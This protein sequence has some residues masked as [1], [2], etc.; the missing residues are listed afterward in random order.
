V[1]RDAIVKRS[2]G[3]AIVNAS[4]VAPCR[5]YARRSRTVRCETRETL[6]A[7]AGWK[8]NGPRL[9]RNGEAAAAASHFAAS[10][11]ARPSTSDAAVPRC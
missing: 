11:T 8:D 5:R 2:S 6:L 9:E 4:P 7:E 10:T 3:Y 1:N